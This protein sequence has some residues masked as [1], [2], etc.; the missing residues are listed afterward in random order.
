MR[1]LNRRES[2]GMPRVDPCSYLSITVGEQF[3]SSK[4]M[5]SVSSGVCNLFTEAC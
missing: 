3:D 5:D 2:S 1:Q 4:S